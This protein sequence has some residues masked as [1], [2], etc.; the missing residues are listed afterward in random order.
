MSVWFL[1]TPCCRIL[2]AEERISVTRA[3]QKIKVKTKILTETV[4]VRAYFLC[5]AYAAARVKD[6]VKVLNNPPEA[7]GK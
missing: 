6:F 5:L 4:A 1:S 2:A 7:S 3:E